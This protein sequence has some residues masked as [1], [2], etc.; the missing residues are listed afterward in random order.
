MIV[1]VSDSKNKKAEIHFGTHN[2]IFH[3]DEVI[4][5]TILEFAYLN[6][7]SH[8]VR[9][10]NSKVLNELDVVIDVG[11]GSFDHHMAG[12]D[13]RRPT[14][15][16]YASAGLVWKKYAKSAIMNILGKESL[17]VSDAEI[18]EIKEMIDKEIIIPIDMEDNGEKVATHKFSFISS[19][20]PS[21]K[22]KEPDYNFAFNRAEIICFNIFREIVQEKYAQVAAKKELESRYSLGIDDGIWEIPAQ[23][24][25][26]IENV[27]KYNE[28]N[29]NKIK[30]VIYPYPAGGYAAQC[31]P[32]SIKN[33]FGQLVPFP[34]KWAGG[35]E[36]TLPDISGVKDATFCHND[37]FFARAKTKEAVI[38]M[39]KIAIRTA[40]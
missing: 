30:F 28:I 1:G 29:R 25:P 12:F 13:K 40:N 3:C 8:V 5:I 37:C 10:R 35:S 22:D 31:V 19:F 34:R 15:E 20:L 21:W 18:E 33:K 11:G 2:G 27:V 14:G 24:M 26:W 32:P 17:N 4:G 9:T 39:C 7:D 6:V 23:T 38:E 16:K 36:Q